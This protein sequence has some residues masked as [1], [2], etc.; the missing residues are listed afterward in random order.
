MYVCLSV[1]PSICM[2]QHGSHWTISLNMTSEYLSKICQKNS[3]FIKIWQD[4]QRLQM[5]TYVHY[6]NILKD[7]S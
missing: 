3:S 1:C 6:D 7:S 4:K 5:E 2:E